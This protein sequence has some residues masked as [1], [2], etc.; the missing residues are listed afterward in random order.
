MKRKLVNVVIC[1]FSLTM[2]IGQTESAD[3][4]LNKA[5]YQEEVNGDLE[6]A[7]EIYELIV[8]EYPNE[9]TVVAK[10][11][12]RNAYAHEKLGIKTAKGL[13]QKIISNYADQIE[14][15]NLSRKRLKSLSSEIAHKSR[16]SFSIEKI[17]SGKVGLGGKMSFDGKYLT[18]TD[19]SEGNLYYIDVVSKERFPV[20]TD[21]NWGTQQRFANLSIWSPKADRIAYSFFDMKLGWSVRIWNKETKITKTVLKPEYGGFVNPVDWSRDGQQLV[22]VS[23]NGETVWIGLLDLNTEVWKIFSK[24]PYNDLVST[25]SSPSISP[26]GKFILYSRMGPNGNIDAFVISTITGEEKTLLGSAAN[27][28]KAIWDRDGKSFTCVSDRSGSPVLYRYKFDTGRVVGEPE[29]IYQGISK[30]FTPMAINDT[31]LIFGNS[32][33]YSD[34]YTADINLEDGTVSNATL[35]H[36][37]AKG[38]HGPTWSNNGE[39]IAY[40]TGESI[41]KPNQLIIREL[42]TGNDRIIDLGVD[43]NP[44]VSKIRWS[45]DDRQIALALEGVE[46]NIL[47]V[48][49]ENENVDIHEKVG[50]Y[51]V[52]GPEN[53]LINSKPRQSKLYMANLSTK[54]Q[55]TMF[56]GEEGWIYEGLKLV[57]D[58]QSLFFLERNGSQPKRLSKYNL[59]TGKYELFWELGADKSFTE[60]IMCLPDDEDHILVGLTGS[61]GWKSDGIELFKV[62]ILTKQ[63]EKYGLLKDLQTYNEFDISTDLKKIVFKKAEFVSNIWLLHL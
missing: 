46:Y 62:N 56:E 61:K 16:N 59:S 7:I 22:T 19:W 30:S 26:D 23:G 48:D 25:G 2:A 18:N 10:A 31:G 39:F 58:K 35:L 14:I 29:L 57:S 11:M 20:F 21:G 41:S 43:L 34:I 32:S 40:L 51:V 63:R 47:L 55:T 9:R 8:K 13:Y 12:Y 5:I 3:K 1:L 27:E 36:E 42:K 15:V 49:V 52:F 38:F 24:M 50:W 6:K 4:M 44:R 17:F 37:Q 45:P 54:K 60:K 28:S 33:S 53:S